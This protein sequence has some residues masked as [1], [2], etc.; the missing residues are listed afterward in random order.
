LGVTRRD[1]L[2]QLRSQNKFRRQN[3]DGMTNS[4]CLVQDVA[5]RERSIIEEQGKR[6]RGDEHDSGQ[7]MADR[8]PTVAG[9]TNKSVVLAGNKETMEMEEI[10][11]RQNKVKVSSPRTPK[12]EP[13]SPFSLLQ[14]LNFITPRLELQK[15][16]NG[17]PNT[18]RA[19][20]LFSPTVPISEVY[21]TGKT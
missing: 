4:R 8:L 7:I 1:W 17:T 10:G 2:E 11:S 6:E 16:D 21:S 14:D 20:S 19:S 9:V 12:Q 5:E 13:R 15:G 3:G 18:S